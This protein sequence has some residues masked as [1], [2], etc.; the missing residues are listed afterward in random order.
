MIN[1]NTEKDNRVFT[2]DGSVFKRKIYDDPSPP[3]ANANCLEFSW[4]SLH[5]VDVE[6]L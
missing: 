3:L 5:L 6:P 1:L 4:V 2:A